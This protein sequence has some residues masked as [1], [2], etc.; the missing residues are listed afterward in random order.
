M[1]SK[2]TR[3]ELLNIIETDHVQCGEASALS[4]MALAAMD[5]EP[6]AWMHSNNDIGIPAITVSQKIGHYWMAEFENVQPLYR[7]AQPAPVVPT[8]DEWLEIRGSK[9]LGWVKDAM[10]ESYDACRAAMLQAGN[11]PVHS[12]LRPEQN[13][14]SPAQ[15]PIDHG[16]SPV[17]PDCWIPVSERMPETDGNYW[18]WWSE[19]KRQGPVWFIKSELQA[20]FQSHEITHWMPLPAAPQEAK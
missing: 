12:G 15:S 13:I 3:E 5:S 18:G 6:V 19:S 9:P 17:I 1:T 10:R 20:Q 2:L 11:S 16:N 7:H 14:G 8:F 4:R